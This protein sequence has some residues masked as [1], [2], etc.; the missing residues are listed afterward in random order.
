MS[1]FIRQNCFWQLK[2][3]HAAWILSTD[4]VMSEE[5]FLVGFSMVFLRGVEVNLLSRLCS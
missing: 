4:L 1:F 3:L 5:Y 2:V